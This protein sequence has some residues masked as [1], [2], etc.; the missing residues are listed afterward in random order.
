[1]AGTEDR[2]AAAQALDRR[3][4]LRQSLALA[5]GCAAGLHAVR[6]AEAE[7][8]LK[9]IGDA[10]GIHPGRVVWAYDPEVTD[11]KGPRRRPLVGRQPRQTGTGKPDDGPLRL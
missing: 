3:A 5:A 4:F 1:M 6:A 11:W 10:K 7:A 9:P 2:T 8:P